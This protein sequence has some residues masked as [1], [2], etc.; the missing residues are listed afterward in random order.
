MSWHR[1][2][3]NGKINTFPGYADSFG[4]S[5]I[6][7]RWS[8]IR[9]AFVFWLWLRKPNWNHYKVSPDGGRWLERRLLLQ[10]RRAQIW[11]TL[12]LGVV[13]VALH[14]QWRELVLGWCS[15]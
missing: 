1:V 12:A 3:G 13:V 15:S 8:I 5:V 9:T 11:W 10:K 2:G 7:Y 6:T 14:S 4:S